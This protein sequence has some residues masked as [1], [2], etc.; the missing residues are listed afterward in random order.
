MF[1]AISKGAAGCAI[2]G[3]EN[4]IDSEGKVVEAALAVRDSHLAIREA[5]PLIIKHRNTGKMYPVIPHAGITDE[6]YEFEEYIGNVI[7]G[8]NR[9]LPGRPLYIDYINRR[10]N[11]NEDQQTPRGLIIEDEPKLF[12]LTGFFHLRLMPKKSPAISR[13][14]DY[15]PVADFLSVEEGHFNEQGEFTVSRTRNGDQVMFG[16]FW[17]TPSCGLVR[18]KLL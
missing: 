9:Y 8:S 10:M 18:V 13:I 7:F 3:A 1:Y 6:G 5:M 11:M 12:Y 15:L 4:Y 2:F 14:N 16:G 17:V